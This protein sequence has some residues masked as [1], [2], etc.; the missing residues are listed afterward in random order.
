MFAKFAHTLQLFVHLLKFL[1]A[2]R[3]IRTSS[4]VHV[5]SE[6]RSRR[7]RYYKATRILLHESSLDMEE[8]EQRER[9]RKWVGLLLLFSCTH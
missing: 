8:S 7:V 5:P 4:K 1:L 3:F 2:K 6:R 9:E